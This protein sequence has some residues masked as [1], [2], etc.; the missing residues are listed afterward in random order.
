MS[1][2][3]PPRGSSEQAVVHLDCAHLAQLTSSSDSRIKVSPSWLYLRPRW[4][5]Y[6]RETAVERGSAV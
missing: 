1:H 2:R 4:G 5:H 3:A 6:V